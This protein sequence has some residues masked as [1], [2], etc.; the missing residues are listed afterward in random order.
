MVGHLMVHR[1]CCLAALVAVSC[2]NA[3]PADDA[4]VVAAVIHDAAIDAEPPDAPLPPT[5]TKASPPVDT[6]TGASP[7]W[8]PGPAVVIDGTVDGAALRA[9][10]R[11]RLKQDRSPVHVLTGGSALEL[12]QRICEA[13]VPA[14]LPV[15][16]PILLKPN[17]SGFDWFKNVRK[18]GGD[19]GVTG[20]TTD[21]EF[22]RGV[23]RCLRA[24]GHAAAAITVADGFG[25][26]PA[27]WDRLVRVSG[28]EAM[29]REEGVRLVALD[30]DGKYDVEGDQPG[31]PL[32][33]T[34]MEKT[35]VPTLLVPK[36]YAEHLQ[37]GLVI[38]LP[39]LKAH[40]FAVFSIGIKALQGTAMYSD[41]VPAYRQKWRTH[42]EIGPALELTKRGDPRAR[43]AYV[44]S[45]ETF[46][47]RMVD[48]LEI[49]APHLVLAEGAP[50]MNGDGFQKLLPLPEHVAIGGSNVI[51]VDRVGAAFLGMWDNRALARELGGHRTS[52]LLT[53]AAA[54]FGVDIRDPR[55]VGD[56]AALLAGRRPTHLVG[57]A[58]FT[59]DDDAPEREP[60]L[61]AARI[62][63]DEAPALD[64]APDAIWDRAEAL[65]FATDWSGRTTAAATEVRAL[66]SAQAL[67]L[68]W[69][70]EGHGGFTDR[71]RP[72]D[73]ERAGLY[74]EDCVELFFTPDPAAPDRYLELEVG[75][76]GHFFDLKVDRAAR[77]AARSDV[78][79]SGGLTIGTSQDA[80]A[81]RAVIEMKITA[82]DVIGALAP[83][84]ALPIGLYRME[85][86]DKR[87]YLAAFPT[88]T[89][90]P[91]FHVPSAFGLLLV[92]P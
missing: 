25:G 4:A 57:M 86:R 68:R 35:T 18:S 79:W 83:G 29:T 77:G 12:G 58:G 87:L 9:A 37:R 75:P 50:A 74:E 40:R 73:V 34:G 15:G 26:Q 28:Y 89:P 16:T 44:K 20:R 84:A 19:N 6:V 63:D 80:G 22:V 48:I 23:I 3:R 30:D 67:Y 5:P 56:G 54:R 46:S 24:H 85:G 72:I 21:P 14:S 47:K 64:G 8:T 81:K 11:A 60:H 82:P 2:G 36:A 43:A 61:H 7:A 65:R 17:M 33:I 66:W 90:K 59:V 42:K 41:A 27:D 55:V 13:V 49:Q 78:A 52:P 69:E 62:E 53:M 10:N 92:D 70:L 71:T 76:F 39:K 1:S 51:L 38:S 45:L 32:G 31:K 91:S 88:R